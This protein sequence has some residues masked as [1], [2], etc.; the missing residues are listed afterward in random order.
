MR[1]SMDRGKLNNT[2]F[3]YSQELTCFMV[4]FEGCEEVKNPYHVYTKAFAIKIL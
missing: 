2:H 4:M 1:E 3:Q